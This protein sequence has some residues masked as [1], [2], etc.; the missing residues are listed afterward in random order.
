[1]RVG[2]QAKPG[3]HQIRVTWDYPQRKIPERVFTFDVVNPDFGK[4]VNDAEL[5]ALQARFPGALAAVLQQGM[6][7]QTLGLNGY[8]GCKDAWMS[9]EGFAHGASR[10]LK[11]GQYKF[12]HAALLR[13]DL[14]ALPQGA[15]LES[16]QLRLHT[17][18]GGRST[19]RVA[20]RMLRAWEA[21]TSVN[22]VMQGGF[23][24][25]STTAGGN[26]PKEGECGWMYA[27][28]PER[29]GQPGAAK[30]GVDREEAPLAA[31]RPVPDPASPA[32]EAR[33]WI[34][35]DVTAAARDWVAAPERNFGLQ[36]TT[37]GG[38]GGMCEFA[39]SESI[40]PQ[41]RPQ[42]VLIY[43]PAR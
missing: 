16:A 2:S 39:S 3:R 15:I 10:W 37:L 4:P 32:G 27:R 8:Q 41:N 24:I 31:G 26:S 11:T 28:R 13:F 22:A 35:W 1:M 12:D 21:G 19:D 34:V 40:D 20:Y 18:L 23:L 17:F 38:K 14:P 5:A 30:P 9:S 6:P 29:W 36:I 7:C 42:L 25:E 33:A 43:R